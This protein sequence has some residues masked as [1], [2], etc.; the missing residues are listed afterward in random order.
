MFLVSTE[1]RSPVHSFHIGICISSPTERL[2]KQIVLLV[3]RDICRG[4]LG[5]G[6]VEERDGKPRMRKSKLPFRGEKM[7]LMGYMMPCHP[8]LLGI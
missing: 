4:T 1:G 2:L 8:F 7:A 5:I 3:R 6:V